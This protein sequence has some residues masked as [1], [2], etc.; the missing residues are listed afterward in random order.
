MRADIQPAR[1]ADVNL[2]I[3][4]WYDDVDP[5]NNLAEHE[6][7]LAVAMRKNSSQ[8]ASPAG[9]LTPAVLMTVF[10]TLD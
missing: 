4:L 7:R 1:A 6:V 3:F 8:D 9:A 10:R 2:F 5:T